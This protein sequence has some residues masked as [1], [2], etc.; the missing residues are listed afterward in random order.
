[1]GGTD[2]FSHQTHKAFYRALE[3][4]PVKEGVSTYI[5]EQGRTL[6]VRGGEVR[7]EDPEQ[8]G[9]YAKLSGQKI[10]TNKNQQDAPDTSRLEGLGLLETEMQL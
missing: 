8:R 2:A 1:L 3:M 4:S 5:G 9:K 7:R 10:S 6:E